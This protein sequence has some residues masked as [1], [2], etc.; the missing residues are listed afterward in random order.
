MVAERYCRGRVFLAGDAVHQLSPTGALGM[1]TGI[2]D[3]VDLGWKL[4]AAL[5]GWGGDALLDS[6]GLERQPVFRDV[7][8]DI[9]GGWI[10]E[11]RAFLERYSPERD[12]EEF[13]RQFE[14]QTKGFG[15]RL[16]D[17]EPHYEGSPVVVGPPGAV[18]SAHGSHI[19]M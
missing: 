14:E 16:R 1:N 4:A 5:Q 8:E 19:D 3:V 9:I 18:S 7:G 13:A 2:G 17:F 6:Y 10:R 15:R 12:R 11:D